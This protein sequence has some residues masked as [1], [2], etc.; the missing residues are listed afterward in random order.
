MMQPVSAQLPA[1]KQKQEPLNAALP[2][3]LA[4][5][6]AILTAAST[7]KALRDWRMSTN[8]KMLAQPAVRLRINPDGSVQDG[9]PFEIDPDAEMAKQ[10][11]RG[12]LAQSYPSLPSKL[13][14]GVNA[15]A[16]LGASVVTLGSGV[17]GFRQSEL[18]PKDSQAR[19]EQQAHHRQE[20][21]QLTRY[22]TAWGAAALGGIAGFFATAEAFN[23]QEKWL[24]AIHPNAET[25]PVQQMSFSTARNRL[26]WRFVPA[27]IPTTLLTGIAGFSSA[28]DGINAVAG[29]ILSIV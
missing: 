12:R 17:A 11:Q 15:L 25:N 10:L 8:L 28:R 18:A 24:R 14:R 23:R 3:V 9:A 6:S 19:R 13:F 1:P 27:M 16:L 5:G 26:L 4:T 20:S 22:S 7:K 2:W 21:Q 29:G